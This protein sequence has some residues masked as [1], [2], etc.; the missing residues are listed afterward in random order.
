M[1]C[2]IRCSFTVATVNMWFT[3]SSGIARRVQAPSSP[4]RQATRIVL[5]EGSG[6][7]A[8]SS[9]VARL[10]SPVVTTTSPSL[11]RRTLGLAPGA[12]RVPMTEVSRRPVRRVCNSL[13]YSAKLREHAKIEPGLLIWN[14]LAS[15]GAF[16][17]FSTSSPSEREAGSMEATARSA[18]GNPRTCPAWSTEASS[19][20]CVCR[21]ESPSRAR[22]PTARVGPTD[23][24]SLSAMSTQRSSDRTS[25]HRR[26]GA[27]RYCGAMFRAD[28][29]GIW[30]TNWPGANLSR[31]EESAFSI[32]C[33]SVVAP[34]HTATQGRGS[35]GIRTMKLSPWPARWLARRQIRMD[36]RRYLDTM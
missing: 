5:A 23:M 9:L 22:T 17:L 8:T 12:L 1:L 6:G 31:E 32:L 25:T 20:Q 27:C 36:A 7:F 35:L 34:F 15:S 21:H 13:G 3:S 19:P 18:N 11:K 4:G 24:I 2:T 26:C 30:A 28:W 16:C 10:T 14:R 29:F 33:R